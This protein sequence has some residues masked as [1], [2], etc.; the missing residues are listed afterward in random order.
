MEIGKLPN[1]V[2]QSLVL[3]KFQKSRKEVV[4]RPAIGEDCAA[5]DFGREICVAS[6]DPITGTE[7]EIGKIAVHVSCND[8]AASGAE[9]IGLLVTLLIPPY[10]SDESL[11]KV[12]SQL[13]DTAASINVEIVGGHTEVT[14]A[15]NRF[16]ICITAFGKTIGQ[17]IIKTSG[18]RPG[19]YLI[20]TK[21][22][23]LEGTSILAHEHQ[24]ELT[25]RFGAEFVSGAKG[26]IEQISVVKEGLIASRNKAHAMHDVTE[27]GVLGAIWEMCNASGFGVEVFA[28]N[29]P[30][31]KETRDICEY[32]NINPLK[33]ISSGSML[34]SA[35]DGPALIEVLRKEGVK[36]TIIGKITENTKMLLF[37]GKDAV[38][39]SPPESDELY[40]VKKK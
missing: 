37:T 27:G 28:E 20:L 40:K 9:P 33:L 2:L 13:S 10:A 8:I 12:I 4:V 38:I 5:V 22:A 15:V 23:A 25:D 11:D 6:T 7:N 29:I 31:L 3:N 24:D 36:A 17:N 30:I 21:H 19:D 32:F 35:C 14:D 16:V 34:V 39:I 1:E 18:A 26:L